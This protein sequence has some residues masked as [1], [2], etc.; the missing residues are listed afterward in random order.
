M[1]IPGS[2]SFGCED[3][4]HTEGFWLEWTSYAATICLSQ[5]GGEADHG[6]FLKQWV[7]RTLKCLVLCCFKAPSGMLCSEL[8]TRDREERLGWLFSRPLLYPESIHNEYTRGSINPLNQCAS[9]LQT[10]TESA[11]LTSGRIC[12][13]WP[14]YGPKLIFK[15]SLRFCSCFL[16][17]AEF[18]W[19]SSWHVGRLVWRAGQGSLIIRA[20]G[21]EVGRAPCYGTCGTVTL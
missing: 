7:W 18:L 5:Y 20:A 15:T 21:L 3:R 6:G 8:P 4:T 19:G 9:S 12:L 17:E 16:L 14:I 2:A 11:R 1:K 13:Y 10:H